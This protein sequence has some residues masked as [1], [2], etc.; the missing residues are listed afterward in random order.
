VL[1]K[2]WGFKGVTVSDYIGINELVTRHKLAATPKEGGLRAFKAGVDIETP[3][4]LGYKTLAE[5]VKEG[6]HRR[7]RSTLSCAASW[8]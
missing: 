4:G 2:E 3:D 1:R 6:K 8:N 5:L 7:R